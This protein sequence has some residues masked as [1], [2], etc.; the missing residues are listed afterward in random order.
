M[1][2][3]S[4]CLA[5]TLSYRPWD[6]TARLAPQFA[7]LLNKMG[8]PAPPHLEVSL[9]FT[10]PE[11]LHSSACS[12]TSLIPNQTRTY[13]HHFLLWGIYICLMPTFFCFGP[14]KSESWLN[15]QSILLSVSMCIFCCI[16]IDG[17]SCW[18]MESTL[19]IDMMMKPL[20]PDLAVY[21]GLQISHSMYFCMG[22]LGTRRRRHGALEP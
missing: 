21:K 3:T 11:T 6:A 13:K 12:I 16:M 22:F 19:V 4:R 2:W 10:A 14:R 8:R 1:R 17:S 18:T 9:V 20:W 5:D 15:S 7:A